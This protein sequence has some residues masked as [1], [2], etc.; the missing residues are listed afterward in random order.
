MPKKKLEV[1]TE[2]KEAPVVS[3]K[4]TLS[5]S[6]YESRLVEMAKK[7][8]TAEKIGEALRREGIHP[9]EHG[10]I[11]RILR[12]AGHYTVPDVKNAEDKLARLTAQMQK[13]A[14]DKRAMRERERILSLLRRQ[15]EYHKVQ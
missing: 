13:N 9:K 15:K 14:Q 6:E 3:T 12:A 8:I 2:K 5:K 11:S 1:S 4:K 10:K 7:G